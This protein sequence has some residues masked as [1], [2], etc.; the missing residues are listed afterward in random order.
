MGLGD[1]DACSTCA[2]APEFS[3]DVGT[4]AAEVLVV[5][6][7]LPLPRWATSFGYILLDYLFV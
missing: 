2:A 5:L 6:V 4:T 1:A 3:G 7:S